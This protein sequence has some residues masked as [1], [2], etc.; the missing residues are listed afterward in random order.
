MSDDQSHVHHAIDYVEITVTDLERAKGFYA[1]AF[2]WSFNDHGPD[3]A[4][5]RW[6]EGDGE[7]GGLAVGTPSGPGGVA[8]L[9][10]SDDVDATVL[11]I[12]AAGGEVVERPYD[13]PRGRRFFFH[14]PDGNR[15]GVWQTA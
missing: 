9:L 1:A 2:G 15:L 3:Y 8:V 14:D 13:F 7:V 11:A 6:S 12:E 5:I 10:Y 4:G